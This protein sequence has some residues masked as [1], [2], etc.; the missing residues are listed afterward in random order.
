MKKFKSSQNNLEIEEEEEEDSWFYRPHTLTLLALGGS[1]LIYAAFSRDATID[2][3]V[4]N[5]K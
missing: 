5:I 1:V 4:G 3:T 2:D